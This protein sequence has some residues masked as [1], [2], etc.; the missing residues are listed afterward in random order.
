MR[1]SLKKT[2]LKIPAKDIEITSNKSQT[3][4]HKSN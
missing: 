3:A 2:R 1:Y 4:A